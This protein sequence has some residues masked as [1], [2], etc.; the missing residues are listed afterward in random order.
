VFRFVVECKGMKYDDT[1]VSLITCSG[2]LLSTVLMRAVRPFKLI[3]VGTLMMISTVIV[4]SYVK[5]NEDF[6]LLYIGGS[7]MVVS[8]CLN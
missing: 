1:Y 7:S 3:L 6:H 8:F 2:I 4:Y 5:M